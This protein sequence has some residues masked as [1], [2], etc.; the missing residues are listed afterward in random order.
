L[1]I[2]PQIYHFVIRIDV[3]MRYLLVKTMVSMLN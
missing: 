3:I 2:D 1:Q